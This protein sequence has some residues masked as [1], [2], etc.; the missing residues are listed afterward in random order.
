MAA[1]YATNGSIRDSFSVISS[2]YPCVKTGSGV[3][4]AVFIMGKGIKRSEL[5]ADD[6]Y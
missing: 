6:G 3:Y 5:V 4:P 1:M 2:L